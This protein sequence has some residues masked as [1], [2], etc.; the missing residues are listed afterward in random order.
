M[1]KAASA[2]FLGVALIIASVA[3]SFGLEAPP[4]TGRVVD[5]AHV[6]PAEII[7]SLSTTLKAHEDKTTN[8]V[9]VLVLP[10]LEGEPIEDFAQRTFVTWKLGQKGTDN[11]SLLVIAINDRK[12]RIHTGYGLEGALTDARSSQII[13]NE[14]VPRFR[15]GDFAGGI[16]AGTDAILK[17]IE[18]TYRASERPGPSA[19]IDETAPK[20]FFAIIVGLIIGLL[21]SRVHRGL[22]A[23]AGGGL[24]ALLAPWVVPSLVAAGASLLLVSLLSAVSAGAAG[25]AHRRGRAD[26]WVW[27]TG[28]GGGWSGGNSEDFGGFSGGGGDSGGGGASG[29][30]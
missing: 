8:Q 2:C 6:L 26:D 7:E 3:L 21:L 17:T 1:W 30:W 22:G 29:S 16:Q 11:G 5:L 27:Y 23:M 12:V 19:S 14:I 13:R 9:A 24:S 25:R 28:S 4:L 20:V 18:G 15:A 10:S